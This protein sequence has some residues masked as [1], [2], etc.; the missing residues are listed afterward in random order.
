MNL[1]LFASLA[2]AHLVAVVSPGPDF[3]ILLKAV[4]KRVCAAASYLQSALA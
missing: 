1:T 2:F 3:F 4:L